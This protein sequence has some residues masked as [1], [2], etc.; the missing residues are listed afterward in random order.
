M[1][2][3]LFVALSGC[4]SPPD[5]QPVS[6]IAE[7]AT[8]RTVEHTFGTTEIPVDPQRIVALGE[9]GLLVDLLDSGITPVMTTVNVVGN[10]ALASPEELEG[11]DQ[12][13]ST[14]NIS[15]ETVV[16]YSLDLIIASVFFA[17]RAGYDRLNAI[18]PTV[19]VG[20]STFEQ[21]IDTMTIFGQ[22]DEAQAEI[23]AF[24]ERIAAESAQ[25]NAD[26]TA[27]SI[28]AIYAGPSVALFFEDRLGPPT[29]LAEMGVTL[30]PTGE[31]RN[32]L[33]VR[34]G[35]AYLSDE[36]LDLI[37]GEHL[38]LLQSS[39]VDGEM[40]SLSEMQDNAVWQAV[41]AVKSGNVSTLDRIGY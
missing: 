14:G 36:R 3:I 24:E 34:G 8:T 25:I 15:L 5:A 22:G 6:V 9:E 23:V 39:A 32:N 26:Q 35:R 28:G 1:V 21:Y 37:S 27:I 33:R 20:G 17:D 41:P 30:L 29:M 18:A 12:F 31:E 10:V 7:T 13:S 38:I 16:T 40:D 2:I 11:I 4:F 19:T